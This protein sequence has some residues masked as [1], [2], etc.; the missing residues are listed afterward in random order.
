MDYCT[1]QRYKLRMC[2]SVWTPIAYTYVPAIQT[3]LSKKFFIQSVHKIFNIIF[4][5]LKIKRNFQA[6]D[7]TWLNQEKRGGKRYP[8]S[9]TWLAI[10]ICSIL[11]K[12]IV[13]K[14]LRL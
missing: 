7:L 5:T 3:E 13:Q 8:T 2:G 1:R 9:V 6:F 11:I 12:F 14:N 10:N 4:K